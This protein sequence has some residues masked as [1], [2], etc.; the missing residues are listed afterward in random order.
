MDLSSAH[1]LVARL[2]L[3]VSLILAPSLAVA[4]SNHAACGDAASPLTSV[5]DVN[6][7]GTVD[8]TDIEVIAHHIDHNRPYMALYDR[9]ADGAVTPD[10]LVLATQDIGKASTV[11]DQQL[12]TY[13]NRFAEFQHVVGIDQITALGYFPIPAP[14][15]GHGVHWLNQAGSDSI[16]GLKQADDTIAEGLNVDTVAERVHA[17]FWGNPA[18]PVF[19]NGALD[20]PWGEQWKDGH[21]VAFANTAPVFTDS[22]DEY[23]HTHAGLCI[24]G[25][26]MPD[27]N[28]N[29]TIVARGDQYL[30][31]NECQALPNVD[32]LKVPGGLNAWLNIYMIHVWL[33]DLNPNGVFGRTHPCVEPEGQD[34][35]E[36]NALAA[37]LAADRGEEWEVPEFFQHH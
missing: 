5:A 10:D 23:W 24:T 12:A 32:E 17:V 29:I 31:F 11:V 7:D 8:G 36:L 1:G 15:K 3:V 35:S 26:Y 6:A 22:P 18:I 21:L 19:D 33:F 27:A 4:E 20:Y 28:G 2:S 16:L 13:Y 9:N 34:E 14:L 37:Q 25:S 30:S